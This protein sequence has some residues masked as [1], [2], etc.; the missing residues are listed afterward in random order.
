MKLPIA[1]MAILATCVGCVTAGPVVWKERGNIVS[2]TTDS[3]VS[4][5]ENVVVARSTD[6]EKPTI[7]LPTGKVVT[8]TGGV[9]VK[10][11]DTAVVLA[12]ALENGYTATKDEYSSDV[13]HIEAAPE[14]SISIA[15]KVATLEVVTTAAPNYSTPKVLK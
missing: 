5:T 14:D 10:S 12:W 7:T 2:A 1:V 6:S 3:T 15:N 4:E 13:V 11:K 9:Y 8:L